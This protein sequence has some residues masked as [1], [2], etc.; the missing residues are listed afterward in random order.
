MGGRGKLGCGPKP[1]ILPRA[2]ED[3]CKGPIAYLW[4]AGHEE[5]DKKME[6][7]V[8]LGFRRNGKDSRNYNN[9]LYRDYYKDPILLSQPAKGK[10]VANILLGSA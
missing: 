3:I 2:P 1:Y 4:L 6:T 9:G 8:G 7:S 10:I 5:L